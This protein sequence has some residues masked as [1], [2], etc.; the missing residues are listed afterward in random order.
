MRT[1]TRWAAGASLVLSSLLA[2]CDPGTMPHEN[3]GSPFVV[4]NPV[5]A[6]TVRAGP[7]ALSSS[8]SEVVFVSLPTGTIPTG[9]AASISNRRTGYSSVIPMVD[10]GMDPTAVPAEVGDTLEIVVVR[11]GESPLSFSSTVSVRARPIVVRSNPPRHKRDVP[12]NGSLLIVFSEPIDAASLN[13]TAIQLRDGAATIAGQ[14]EFGDPAHVSVVF[15]PAAP[16]SPSTNYLLEVTSELRDVS[17]DPLDAPVS[18]PFTTA[19]ATITGELRVTVSTEGDAPDADG[20]VVGISG[21][22]N[23]SIAANGAAVYSLPAN[24]YG[25]SLSGVAAN[26]VVL[27][28]LGQSVEVQAGAIREVA[29]RVACPVVPPG[30]LI[31]TLTLEVYGTGWSLDWF[32][33]RVDNGVER[34]I[35]LNGYVVI[36]PISPGTHTVSINLPTAHWPDHVFECTVSGNN[37][38]SVQ[39]PADA[40]ARV[41]FSGRCIP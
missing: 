38:V 37:T 39:V 13:E 17:G 10:G 9:I 1:V 4:S 40:I 23:Q 35:T 18:I 14:L 3:A 25:V 34:S 15:T 21:Q 32:R 29:F 33:V 5:A 31:I 28:P 20:Y 22:S 2:A 11:S 6:S 30:S 7:P 19:D 27:G 36:N 24:T 8:S 26:C 16:L 12:L 41:S